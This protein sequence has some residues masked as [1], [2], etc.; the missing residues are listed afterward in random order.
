VNDR[1]RRYRQDW[2]EHVERM[3]AGRVPKMALGYRPKPKKI[4]IYHVKVEFM[5]AVKGPSA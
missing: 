5:E 2:V 4:L 1:I 3:K